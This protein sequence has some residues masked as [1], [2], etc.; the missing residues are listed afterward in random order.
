MGA[1]SSPSRQRWRHAATDGHA[2]DDL[3]AIYT[4]I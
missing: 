1:P 2:E 3:A 4:T